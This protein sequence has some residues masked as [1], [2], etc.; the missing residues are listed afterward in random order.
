M[1]SKR[2]YK[3]CQWL[4]RSTNGRGVKCDAD[5]PSQCPRKHSN[6]TY[7]DVC[8]VIGGAIHAPAPVVADVFEA[9]T[10]CPHCGHN[11]K[12]CI[13]DREDR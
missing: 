7:G 11:L 1:S 4:T 8:G 3:P 9:L 12:I 2:K 10:Y 5:Q 13:D 6:L